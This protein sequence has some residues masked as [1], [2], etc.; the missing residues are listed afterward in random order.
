M[1]GRRRQ[2]VECPK[3]HIRYVLTSRCFDNGA[4]ITPLIQGSYEAYVLYCV[5]GGPPARTHWLSSELKT[6]I[7]STDAFVRGYGLAEEIQLL[8]SKHVK[9]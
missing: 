5:C 7:V 8:T 4:R 2:C 1:F 6:Y 3:C 9:A